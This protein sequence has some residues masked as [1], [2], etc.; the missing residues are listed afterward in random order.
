MG[1]K[2]QPNVAKREPVA[3]TPINFRM[4]AALRAR[5]RRFARERSLGEA[6]ALRLVVS[7]HLN[8]LDDEHDRA[9]AD[10]WQL[11]QALAT[12]ERYR[13]GAEPIVSADEIDALFAPFAEG[14][15]AR[16]AR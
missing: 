14:R 8:E 15:R 2:A 11:D 9:E 6:E 10:R 3:T 7:E 4:P 16:P 5:L 13:R 1:R 12:F